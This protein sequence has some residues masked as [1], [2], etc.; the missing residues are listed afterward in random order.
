VTDG[1]NNRIAG[2][3]IRNVGN[4]AVKI[5]GGTNKG[6]QGSDINNCGESGILYCLVAIEKHWL[7]VAIMS[8]ITAYMISVSGLEPTPLV[9]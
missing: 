2:C 9:L 7:P 5:D 4:D 3:T 1:R 6:V 8:P